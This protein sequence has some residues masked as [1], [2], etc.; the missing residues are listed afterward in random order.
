MSPRV[1]AFSTTRHGGF[2]RGAYGGFNINRYCGDNES[3]VD[4]NIEALAC[5][6]D[7]D[8]SRIVIPHQVHGV[9][10]RQIGDE[11][12]GLPQSVRNM[13]VEGVDAVMTDI[14]GVCIGV[15]TADCVPVIIYDSVRNAAAVVHAGWRGTVSRIVSRAVC[16]MCVSFGSRPDSLHAVIGPG[17]SLSAFEV[18]D[19]VYGEFASAGFDMSAISCRKDK[20]HIDLFGCNRM[21]LV[22]SGLRE[23]NIFVSGICT[24]NN[25]DDYFSA[26]RLGTASGRIFTGIVLR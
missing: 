4:R 21:Q 20:W 24:Y 3:C 26:R 7:V 1:T 8:G 11:F 14:K 16:A 9:E 6:L 13:I 23:D 2:S 18:G 19:E 25:V 12:F 22:D 17:I 15:S 10:I 5:E